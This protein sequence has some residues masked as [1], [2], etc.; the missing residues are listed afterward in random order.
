MWEPRR[1]TTL[2]AFTACYRES[3]VL[4]PDCDF[5]ILRN[6]GAHASELLR[7]AYILQI[8]FML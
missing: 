4:L 5:K 3:I 8:N 2:Q 6:D 7:N 1:L